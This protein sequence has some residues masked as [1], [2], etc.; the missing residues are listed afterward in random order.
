M[1]ARAELPEGLERER[2]DQAQLDGFVA[3]VHRVP[4]HTVGAND[5]PDD[6]VRAFRAF[7]RDLLRGAFSLFSENDDQW[8][9]AVI[10]GEVEFLPVWS[11]GDAAA[12]WLADF[13]GYHV[14]PISHEALVPEF[15]DDIDSAGLLVG[16]GLEPGALVTFHPAALAAALGPSGGRALA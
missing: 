11:S 7:S 6:L 12:A 3:Q 10:D 2:F 14:R 16:L 5:G 9:N 1:H 15:L 13:P 4:R 8:A